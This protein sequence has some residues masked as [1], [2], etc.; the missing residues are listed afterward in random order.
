MTRLNNKMQKKNDGMSNNK[1]RATAIQQLTAI[2]QQ[3][4]NVTQS[5]NNLA[6]LTHSNVLEINQRLDDVSIVLQALS[7]IV[8]IEQVNEKSKAIRIKLVEDEAKGNADSVQ[9]AFEAGTLAK[10]EL[11]TPESLIVMSIKKEDGSPTYP[12]KSYMAYTALK[13]EVQALV[14]GKKVGEIVTIPENNNTVE[15]LD[16]YVEVVKETPEVE[17]NTETPVV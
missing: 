11:V 14:N 6:K 15:I 9:K 7:Q 2:Q 1:T 12:T 17:I 4:S 10:A 5:H 13:P 16:I 3:L 8:G